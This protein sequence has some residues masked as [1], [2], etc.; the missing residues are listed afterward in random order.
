ME[1]EWV[2]INGYKISS[3]GRII[4]KRGNEL[5]GCI[6]KFGYKGCSVDL[7][8]GY[9]R[10]NNFHRVISMAFI[11]NPNNLPEVNHIDGNKLN[12]RVDNLEWVTKKE[13]QQHASNVLKRR[14]GKYNYHV[15]I[16]EEIVLQIYNECKNTDKKIQ[17]YS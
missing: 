16:T 8:I 4:G 9:G 6:T 10:A 5:E 1:E 17:R 12:N 3:L 7:G 2:E 15:K 11:P 13:N 14:A